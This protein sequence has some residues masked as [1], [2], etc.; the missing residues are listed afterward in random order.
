MKVVGIGHGTLKPVFTFSATASILSITAANCWV[1]NIRLLSDIDN[2]VTAISLGASA[3]GCVL[4]NIEILDGATNKEFLI[5]VAIAAACHDVTIDN[6]RVFGLA[7]GATAAIVT[8]G[9][10]NNLAIVNSMVQGTFSTALM[11]LSAA[12]IVNLTLA[13]NL[14][15]NR[16]SGAGLVYKGHATSTGIASNNRFGGVKNNTETVSQ[17]GTVMWF[18]NYG[19]DTAGTTGILTPATVTAWS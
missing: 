9:A 19:T 2:C 8:A 3:D 4:K 5:D 14:C 18:E 1:E 15:G 12:A 10:S 7:G 13:N 11:D 6:L 17:P 16:D